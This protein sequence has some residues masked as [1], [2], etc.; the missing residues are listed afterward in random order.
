MIGQASY[1]GGRYRLRMKHTF[2]K[3]GPLI[4]GQLKQDQGTRY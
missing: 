2:E 1:Q 3:G 4:E